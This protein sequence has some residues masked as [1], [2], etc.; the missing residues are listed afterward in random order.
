MATCRVTNGDDLPVRN[1]L[2]FLGLVGATILGVAVLL[3]V[4]GVVFLIIAALVAVAI[5]ALLA[6]PLLVKLPW[7]RNR[8]HVERYGN[9]Q[10]IR[11]GRDDFTQSEERRDQGDVIDV[12]GRELPDKE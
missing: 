9:A 3:P 10:T 11:F 5:L 1:A 6:A 8:I 12:E 4:L 2:L 7:F